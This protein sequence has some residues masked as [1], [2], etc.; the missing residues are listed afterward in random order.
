M[1]QKTFVP[2]SDQ[3]LKIEELSIESREDQI[4]LYGSLDITRD[5]EGL[6]KAV[7]LKGFLENIIASLGQENLPE[8][9]PTKPIDV[10][11]NPF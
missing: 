3:A 11:D 9:L 10:V 1:S 8:K 7:K 5:K 6:D 4:S 2:F